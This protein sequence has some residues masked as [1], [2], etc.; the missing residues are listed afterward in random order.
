[1]NAPGTKIIAKNKAIGSQPLALGSWPLAA[2]CAESAAAFRAKKHLTAEF[3]EGAEKTGRAIAQIQ[4]LREKEIV[5]K[6][7][8]NKNQEPRAKCR[9]PRAES[10]KPEA[11]SPKLKSRTPEA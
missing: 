7:Q 2:T 10:P 3:A 9:K 1:M 5:F 4:K 8:P 11:R 6:S